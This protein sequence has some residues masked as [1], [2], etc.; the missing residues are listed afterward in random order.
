MRHTVTD[1]Q[2]ISTSCTATVNV[3]FSGTAPSCAF[4]RTNLVSRTATYDGTASTDNDESGSSIVSFD[5]DFGDST[6]GTGPVV[7]RTYAAAG[8]YTVV[9]TVTDDEGDTATCSQQSTIP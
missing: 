6:S 8:T 1:S 9:L 3:V 2:G 5:W 7:N 4:T